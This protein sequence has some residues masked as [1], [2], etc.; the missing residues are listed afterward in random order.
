MVFRGNQSGTSNIMER[1]EDKIFHS[2]DGCWYWTAYTD[3]KGYGYLGVTGTTIISAHRFSYERHKGPI[4]KGMCVCH[5]C[6]NPSCVNPDHLW[7]GSNDD[8]M[9]DMAIKGRATRGSRN[10]FAKLN[11]V[12]IPIIR[13]AISTGFSQSEVAK[14]FKISRSVI[15]DIIA[16]RTWKH[17]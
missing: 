11:E 6:D 2:P 13:E 3:R 17:I 1:F 9:R 12:S 10:T 5:S 14:Y 8:N 15:C 16:K 7:L 4:P